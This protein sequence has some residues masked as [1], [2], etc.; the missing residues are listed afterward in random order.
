MPKNRLTELLHDQ[1]IGFELI[2][3]PPDYSALEAAHDTHT[4][5]S[6]F[7][8]TVLINTDAGPVLAVLPAPR[9]VDFGKLAAVTGSREVRLAEENAIAELFPDCQVGAEPPFGKL[10]D[11]PVFVDEELATQE[12]ITFNAGTHD[13]AM[14]IRFADYE[15]LEH[16]THA[17]FAAP[18]GS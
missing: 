1:A 2:H 9:M 13:E 14:R 10:Y 18:R 16:P 6:E 17:S 11:M 7:A 4:P 3:H 12:Y 5:G 8:K 15:R